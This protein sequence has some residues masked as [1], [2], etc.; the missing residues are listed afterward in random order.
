[1]LGY[2]HIL[3]LPLGFLRLAFLQGL[4]TLLYLSWIFFDSK[5]LNLAWLAVL[6]VR[7]NAFAA[8]VVLIKDFVDGYVLGITL[9][10]VSRRCRSFC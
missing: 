10:S 8:V 7:L 6:L 4:A 9:S 2:A 3:G 5:K 1:V